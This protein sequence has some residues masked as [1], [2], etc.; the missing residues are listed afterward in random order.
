[1][2][3]RDLTHIYYELNSYLWSLDSLLLAESII[4]KANL[5]KL[6]ILIVIG[7]VANLIFVLYKSD[8]NLLNHLCKLKIYHFG[9]IILFVFLYWSG[10][11]LRLM[12]WT[13]FLD[14]PMSF[15]DGYQIAAFTDLGA[16]VTPTLIGGGPVKLG[17]LMQKGISAG[18]AGFLTILGGTEDTIM[19]ISAIFLSVYFAHESADKIASSVLSTLRQHW[20]KVIIGV[21]IF[22]IVRRLLRSFEAL[23][24][25]NL[26]PLRYKKAYVNFIKGFQTAL[27]EMLDCLKLILREGKLRF[28]LSFS[29]LLLQ[30]TMKFSILFVLL[31]AFG[32]K[33]DTVITYLNQW[34]VYLS[35][36]FIP[37]PGATGGAETLFY[38]IFSDLIPESLLPIVT[39]LWRFGTYYL[40]LILAVLLLQVQLFVR[41]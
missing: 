6:F 24:L 16:A 28:V 25:R 19:Y 37:T 17:L 36:M 27:S 35:M 3:L 13:R 14:T 20:W 23:Q 10:H 34:I 11:A 26:I 32:L 18:K 38:Y 2:R 7:I 31:H 9:I 5:K 1:L 39:T 40:F 15:K 12:I 33:L 41:R 29:I 4:T 30:W 8:A 22:I 21:I